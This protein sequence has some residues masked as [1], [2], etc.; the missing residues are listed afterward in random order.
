[1]KWIINVFLV[2]PCCHFDRQ[3]PFNNLI[4]LHQQ[5][6]R[7]SSSFFLLLLLSLL[8]F[9]LSLSL[10]FCFS[11]IFSVLFSLHLPF[12][13]FHGFSSFCYPCLAHLSFYLA[14]TWF[15]Y[16]LVFVSL[17]SHFQSVFIALHFIKFDLVKKSSQV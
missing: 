3:N 1:M 16:I 6:I 12:G 10:S 13:S 11:L 14:R 8:F 4:H 15:S 9:C 17:D 2:T 5:S 7:D